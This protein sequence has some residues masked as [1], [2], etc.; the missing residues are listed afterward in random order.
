MEKTKKTKLYFTTKYLAQD[1]R[2]NLFLVEDA[3]QAHGSKN[4]GIQA[5]TLGIAAGFSFFSTKVITTGEGGMVTTDDEE[6][7]NKIKTL[8]K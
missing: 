1:V 6:L 5:G 8:L 2:G 7:V 4:K 3:A